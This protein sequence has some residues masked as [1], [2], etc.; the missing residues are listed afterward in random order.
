MSLERS[1]ARMELREDGLLRF[2][3]FLNGFYASDGIGA[4]DGVRLDQFVM[5]QQFANHSHSKIRSRH[6]PEL[7]GC[8]R[9]LNNAARSLDFL[10]GRCCALTFD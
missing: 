4:A 5:H 3:I 1:D 8:Q 7:T 2:Q 6:A 9:L 10:H